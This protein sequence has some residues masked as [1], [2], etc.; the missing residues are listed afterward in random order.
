MSTH[1][2]LVT[3]DQ[4]GAEMLKTVKNMLHQPELHISHV[5]VP[6]DLKPQNLGVY[7]DKIKKIVDK[8]D[9]NLLFL[10]DL[11]G[12]TPYNLINYYSQHKHI[13]ILMGVNLAMLLKAVQMTH[14]DLEEV[15]NEALKSAQKH[16]IQK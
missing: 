13:N 10:C 16:L 4:V 14:L 15:T 12:A 11:Y 3:H 6:S 1:I 7:A 5:S 2:C 9:H 8:I